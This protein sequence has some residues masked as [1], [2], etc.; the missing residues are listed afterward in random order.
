[1]PSGTHDIVIA[2]GMESMSNVPYYLSKARSGYR[3]G[4]GSLLDGLI[5]DGLWDP[6][7]DQHMGQCA[8]SC[9]QKYGISRAQQDDHALETF[10]R[11]NEAAMS[12]ATGM[13]ECHTVIV[14]IDI[15][16]VHNVAH[17]G[18]VLQQL[19]VMYISIHSLKSDVQQDVQHSLNSNATSLKHTVRIT[20][21]HQPIHNTK[22]CMRRACSTSICHSDTTFRYHTASLA[23]DSECLLWLQWWCSLP[24]LLVSCSFDLQWWCSLPILLVSCTFAQDSVC[25]R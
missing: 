19:D 24:I 2:G 3:L 25:S 8:E 14:T 5:H 12:G 9:A 16:V 13:V 22:Y 23:H 11:A 15:H 17:T 21:A 18:M 4:H 6:H 20:L 7:V 1:M 10:R